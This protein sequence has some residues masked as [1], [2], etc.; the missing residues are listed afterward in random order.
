MIYVSGIRNSGSEFV[1][2]IC[3]LQLLENVDHSPRIV[4]YGLVV[5]LFYAQWFVS[6]NVYPHLA[7]SLSP[8]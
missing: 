7:P 1:K 8:L 3:H 4:L 5:Y 2:F 6:L